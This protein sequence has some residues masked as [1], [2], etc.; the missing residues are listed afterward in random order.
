MFIGYLICE[1]SLKFPYTFAK[2][3]SK[4]FQTILKKFFKLVGNFSP[5]SVTENFK[6][7]GNNLFSIYFQQVFQIFL[8]TPSHFLKFVT[9]SP[10]LIHVWMT[11]HTSHT[12][13]YCKLFPFLSA[14]FCIFHLSFS[15]EVHATVFT[16]PAVTRDLFDVQMLV[17][18]CWKDNELQNTY[19]LLEFW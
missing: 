15:I 5:T 3:S 11:L 18:A 17:G 1:I 6:N 16:K 19:A 13:K 10:C 7:R 8:Q 4:L 12:F 14:S 9:K 2:I